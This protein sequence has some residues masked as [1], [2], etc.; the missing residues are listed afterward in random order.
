MKQNITVEQLNDLS[1]KGKEKLRA[2]WKPQEGDR[3]I[4]PEGEFVATYHDDDCCGG[5]YCQYQREQCG[6]FQWSSDKVLPLISIGQMIEFLY[7]HHGNLWPRLG[8]FVFDDNK[9]I[10]CMTNRLCDALYQACKEVLEKE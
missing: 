3:I 8:M 2:W 9:R 10:H 7:E 1:D 4:G 5:D 6:L